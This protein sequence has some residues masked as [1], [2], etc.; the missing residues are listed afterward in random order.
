MRQKVSTDTILTGLFAVLLLILLFYDPIRG[1]HPALDPLFM[2]FIQGVG[3]VLL[4]LMV[5][6][7]IG[8]VLMV[9]IRWSKA[10]KA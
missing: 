9:I 4:A 2:V 1:L 8:L 6:C 10:K 7:I 5:F 3:L